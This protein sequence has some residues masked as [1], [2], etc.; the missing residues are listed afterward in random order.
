MFAVGSNSDVEVRARC[1]VY[2]VRF[3]EALVTA[4]G[5][6][7]FGDHRKLLELAEVGAVLI[8][9]PDHWHKDHAVDA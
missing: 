8:G 9:S 2:P 5:A 4:P 1:D 7:T 6:R 3:R